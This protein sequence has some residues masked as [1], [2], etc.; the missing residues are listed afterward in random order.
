MQELIQHDPPFPPPFPFSPAPHASPL[1]LFSLPY[2]RFIRLRSCTHAYRR[3]IGPNKSLPCPPRA[4]PPLKSHRNSDFPPDREGSA[5]PH[6]SPSTPPP[7][8][9]L[10][11][12]M[13]GRRA[14]G[15]PVQIVSHCRALSTKVQGNAITHAQCLKN[16]DEGGILC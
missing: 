12:R 6:A 9:P 7:S 15:S 8:S 5:R 4:L 10:P 13:E 1:A 2:A 3:Q 11:D 14:L 16:R